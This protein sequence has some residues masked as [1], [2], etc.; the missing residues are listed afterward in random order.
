MITRSESKYTG[1]C[2]KK[3]SDCF[4]KFESLTE[5]EAEL[6]QKATRV[7]HSNM[8]LANTRFDSIQTLLVLDLD[9]TLIHAKVRNF[10]EACVAVQVNSTQLWIT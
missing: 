3:A 6:P 4:Q 7:K 2:E 10:D 8:R 1:N 9:E 5:K